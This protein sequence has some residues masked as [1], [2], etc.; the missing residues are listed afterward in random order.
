MEKKGKNQKNRLP[1]IDFR[2]RFF[3]EIARGD[4]TAQFGIKEAAATRDIALYIK[5]AKENLTFDTRKKNYRCSDIFKPLFEEPAAEFLSSLIH[6]LGYG[7][8]HNTLSFCNTHLGSPNLDVLA[9]ITKAIQQHKVVEIDYS[10]L[11]SP[12]RKREIAPFMV[13][14][15]GYRL[16]VRGYDRYRK[17]FADFLINRAHSARLLVDKDI[18]DV[19]HKENDI[20]WNRIIELELV[21]HPQKIDYRE[22]IEHEYGMQNG[23]LTCHIRAALAGYALRLWSVDCSPE[24]DLKD[25]EYNLWLRNYL[26]LYGVR[27]YFLV[28]G[29]NPE[30]LQKMMEKQSTPS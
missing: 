2:L 3:G 21:P 15:T 5:E 23:V 25:G 20:E 28:P 9:E 7:N 30:S 6:G 1:F 17:R 26:T 24:H 4:L 10:S 11:Q 19:E 29:F 27:N 16:H 18:Q 8:A 22:A 13:I 12:R 14:N